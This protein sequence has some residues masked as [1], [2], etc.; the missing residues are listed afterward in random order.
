MNIQALKTLLAVD[1]PVSGAWNPGDAQA[2]NQFMAEDISR[3]KSAMSGDELFAAT[4]K[5]EFGGLT[6]HKQQIWLA[7]C[8]RDSINPGSVANVELVEWVFGDPSITRSA[9]LAARTEMISL[10]TQES[11]GDVKTGHIQQ[12]RAA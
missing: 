6:D 4:D 8:G 1:H 10:A 2:A 5:G 9:L 7:F 3:V 11:L 12:A